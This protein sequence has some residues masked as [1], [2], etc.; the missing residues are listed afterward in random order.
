MFR[1]PRLAYVT[2]LSEGL[3]TNFKN[4][5]RQTLRSPHLVATQDKLHM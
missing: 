1:L 2:K 3:Y 4:F 5:G